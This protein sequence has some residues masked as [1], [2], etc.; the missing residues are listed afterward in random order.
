MQALAFALRWADEHPNWISVE[1]ELPKR[2]ELFTHD[3]VVVLTLGLRT[4]LG[5]YNYDKGEWVDNTQVTHWMPLPQPPVVSNSGNTGK[6]GG[7]E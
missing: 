5:F 2:D 1:D 4:V 6:K 3:S 7:E